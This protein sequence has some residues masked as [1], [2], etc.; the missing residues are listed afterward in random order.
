[1]RAMSAENHDDPA[2]IPFRQ[3]K[4]EITCALELVRTLDHYLKNDCNQSVFTA[5]MR[6]ELIPLT[7][8]PLGATLLGLVGRMYIEVARSELS[9]LDSCWLQIYET[10]EGMVDFWSAICAGGATLYRSLLLQVP[11]CWSNV[12]CLLSFIMFHYI[13]ESTLTHF[14]HRSSISLISDLFIF[15]KNIKSHSDNLQEQRD[16]NNGVPIHVR[17]SRKAQEAAAGGLSLGPDASYDEKQSF[18]DATRNAAQSILHFMWCM[19]KNDIKCTMRVVCR[20]V[21][22][23][24][25]YRCL[26]L[27]RSTT[28]TLILFF[29]V[30]KLSVCVYPAEKFY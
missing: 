19:T 9:L 15:I 7:E 28:L 1:M 11:I 30:L 14:F 20:K 8:T 6:D 25:R 3:K 13:Y 23:D 22:H 26:F 5:L 24:H 27:I 12:M 21:I 2:L 10:G 29:L 17:E 18:K 4:R 16:D